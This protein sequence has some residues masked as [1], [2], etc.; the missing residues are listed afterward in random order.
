MGTNGS[1]TGECRA[2]PGLVSACSSQSSVSGISAS[3]NRGRRS[4][5]PSAPTRCS[6]FCW[7]ASHFLPS[8]EFRTPDEGGNEA[9]AGLCHS[10]GGR[11]ERRNPLRRARLPRRP[12]PP[13]GAVRE[14]LS[15]ASRTRRSDS[16]ACPSR[17]ASSCDR[18]SEVHGAPSREVGVR[19]RLPEWG[20]ATIVRTLHASETPRVRPGRKHVVRACVYYVA[21]VQPHRDPGLSTTV[22]L[23]ANIVSL[24]DRFPLQCRRRLLFLLMC[25]FV[26]PVSLCHASSPFALHLQSSSLL[27]ATAPRRPPN[28]FA[29]FWTT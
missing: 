1:R 28:R 15:R 10:R 16:D 17:R 22:V 26:L 25:P 14:A 21:R 27:L 11:A 24:S 12:L 13:V 5:G 2:C 8:V 9:I 3:R 18:A 29:S 7:R 20:R 23:P 19:S 4:D 6:L